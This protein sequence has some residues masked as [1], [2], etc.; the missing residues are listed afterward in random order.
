MALMSGFAGQACGASCGEQAAF[1]LTACGLGLGFV[2][3]SARAIAF[4]FLK[5]VIVD[6]GVIFRARHIAGSGA[7]QWP[8]DP[9]D[10]RQ[11]ERRKNDPEN[12]VCR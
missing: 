7:Q 9:G 8:G 6:G 3:Q 5:L 4:E 10:Q 2:D 11:G 12:H 1:D